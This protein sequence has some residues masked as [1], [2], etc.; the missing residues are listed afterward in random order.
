V[1]AEPNDESESRGDGIAEMYGYD[2]WPEGVSI[3]FDR[4]LGVASLK[5]L[6]KIDVDFASVVADVRAIEAEFLVRIGDNQENAQQVR[7]IITEMLLQVAWNQEQPFETCQG[8]W[9]D[10]V[11][12]GFYGIERQCLQTGAF[13]ACCHDYGQTE[14]GLALI[15]PL[16][17]KF[18]RL[19]A[20]PSVT[21]EAAEYYDYELEGLRINRARLEAQKNGTE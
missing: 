1:T 5:Y 20:D 9:N 13:A 4:A 6:R 8:Y 11:Q 12:L 14:I 18:E 16:L 19:R 15:E 21:K 2:K 7:R 3:A 10:L 17:A